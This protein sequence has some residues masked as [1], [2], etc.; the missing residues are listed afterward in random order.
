[1]NKSSLKIA[2]FAIALSFSGAIH[3][4]FT[5]AGSG[6]FGF[7]SLPA[8]SRMTA[9]GGTN[10]SV[11]D[12]DISMAMSN[13]ALLGE[14]TDKNLQLNFCYYM[15]GT[16][17]GSVLYGHNFGRSSWD[18]T[19]GPEKP[20]YFAVGVHYLDYGK[21]KYADSDGN[22]T[23]GTFGARDILLDGIYARQLGPLFTI[24]TTLK[25]VV[26]NYESYNS[27]ALGADIGGHFQ[28]ADS[29]LQVGISLQNI[30]WQLVGFYSAEGGRPR[31]MLPLNL[32]V[33]IS[34]RIP[35]IP[36]RFGMTIHNL[37]SPKLG[38]DYT[39]P[40]T[41]PLTGEKESTDIKTVD[42]VFRHTIFFLDIVDRSDKY[43]LTLSYNHRRRM[44]MVLT[45]QRSMAGFALGGGIRLKGYHVGF[46]LTQLNRSNL[47][48]HVS[49]GLDIND[50]MDNRAEKAVRQKMTDEERAELKAREKAERAARRAR[51]REERAK[52]QEEFTRKLQ[53]L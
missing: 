38:Y 5:G 49:L 51:E 11:R 7:L 18:A 23:G 15:P 21:M 42:M 13:P 31:E 32:Q 39:N 34:Y 47:S 12:G 35:K 16:M 50:L 52:A 9:L 46:S 27:F 10:V 53:G 19:A 30:G 2:I 48:Y 8:S 14:M 33:G 17:F 37:Q 22:L 43:Y 45:D 20:N 24:G 1:M 4:Q 41:S 3:A 40:Y 36:L 26:S 28:T 25:A 29:A 6:V 44:E